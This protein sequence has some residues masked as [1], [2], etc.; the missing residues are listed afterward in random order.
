[1]LDILKI[2]MVNLDLIDVVET[3]KTLDNID[4]FN[5]KFGLNNVSPM[6]S[7]EDVIDEDADNSHL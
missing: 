3:H 2:K 6:V 7:V 1:V 5:Y 4:S